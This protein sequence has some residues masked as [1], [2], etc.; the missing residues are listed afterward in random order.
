MSN[1]YLRETLSIYFKAL[2][3]YHFMRLP[4]PFRVR[5][6]IAKIYIAFKLICD[7]E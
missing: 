2:L 5:N 4:R 7:D 6:D 1:Y 3:I